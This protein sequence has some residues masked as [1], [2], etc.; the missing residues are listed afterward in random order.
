MGNFES[1]DFFFVTSPIHFAYD[2][3]VARILR[4][5]VRRMITKRLLL[6]LQELSVAEHCFG[7][8]ILLL[9]ELKNNL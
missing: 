5:M 3:E 8:R 2:L 6:G 1:P 9:L 7:N 4:G